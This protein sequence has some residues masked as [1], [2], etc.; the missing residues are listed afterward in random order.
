MHRIL[1][2]FLICL[3]SLSGFAQNASSNLKYENYIYQPTIKAVEF[4]NR[5]KEQSFPIIT[6]GSQEEALLAF[7]DLRAG[8]R[9]FSYTLEHCDAEW[10]SSRLSP[11]DYLESYT[12]DRISDYRYSFNTFQKYTHYELT[13]PN[14]AIKPKIPGNYLLKV[15]EDGDPE[16]LILTRRLYVLKPEV[17][18][19]AEITA[20]MQMNQR[21]HQQKINF[22]VNHSQLYIQ[23]PYLDIRALVMQNGR[24]EIAEWAKRPTFV[25]QNQLVYNDFQTFN[26]QGG[27]EFRRFDIRSLRYQSERIGKIIRDTSNT[28]YLLPDPDLNNISYA[29]NYD[30]NGNFYIRNQ[31]GRD[32]RTD[33][34]YAT[35]YFTLTAEKPPEDG[36]AYVVGKFND[37]RLS[38]ENK[39][40][41]DYGKKRFHGSAFVKQGVY[42]YHYTWVDG[43]GKIIDDTVF[44]G[45]HFQTNNNYQLFFYYRGPGARWEELV[46]FTEIK[47]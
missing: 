14:L 40:I 24:P 33:G 45:S 44:D 46:G 4:Y 19:S 26:F 17:T 38:E 30:E 37:Y 21:E 35:I 23:N 32:N 39:L 42:D 15:Y 1:Y 27:N 13:L 18:I 29:F 9:Y 3:I 11:I 20:S 47:K 31:E 28:V 5:N 25:R 8:S 10:N 16:N 36:N 12:E 34:D 41:Y 43:N 2:A 7:D 6:L 22:T